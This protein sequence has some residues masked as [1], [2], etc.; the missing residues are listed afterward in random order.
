MALPGGDTRQVLTPGRGLVTIEETECSAFSDT[1][2]HS[3]KRRL[4]PAGLYFHSDR[5][6]EYVATKYRKWLKSKGVIQSMNR[7]GVMNDDVEMESFFHQFK[8]EDNRR[9]DNKI[10]PILSAL[11]R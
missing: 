6:A 10:C 5:G 7:K 9:G 3:A 8:A 11:T 4:V 2:K 1:F